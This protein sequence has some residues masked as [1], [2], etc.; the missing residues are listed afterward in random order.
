MK[1]SRYNYLFT[2]EHKKYLL[3][4]SYTNNLLEFI[5]NE[6]KFLEQVK[7]NLDLLDEED[8]KIIRGLYYSK[9]R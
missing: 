1:W 2:T 3:Y 9:Q 6:Y 8:K 7:E 4:N 5:K